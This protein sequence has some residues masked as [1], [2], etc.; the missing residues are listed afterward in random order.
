MKEPKEQYRNSR[1]RQSRILASLGV[2]EEF[3]YYPNM[4][5]Y[6]IRSFS[7]K[8]EKSYYY[9]HET[10]YRE[11]NIK[12]RASR[13][14]ALKDPWDDVPCTGYILAKSWKHRSKSTNQYREYNYE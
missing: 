1:K 3:E 5:S 9:M 11:Y 4:R 12:Y 6:C 13:N 7:T 2:L 14:N 10:E 8:Q